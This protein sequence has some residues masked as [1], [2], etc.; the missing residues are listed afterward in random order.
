MRDSHR[1]VKKYLASI[2]FK[3][4]RGGKWIYARCL[5]PNMLGLGCAP[6][7]EFTRM[8]GCTPSLLSMS[9]PQWVHTQLGVRPSRTWVFC[10]SSCFLR[11]WAR[12]IIPE[13]TFLGSFIVYIGI[14]WVQ[15]VFL[16]WFISREF[17][18]FVLK[19]FWGYILFQPIK[20]ERAKN[21]FTR[22]VFFFFFFIK[23]HFDV[24]EWRVQNTSSIV[25][26]EGVY[27]YIYKGK[28]SK[29]V[30]SG[31]KFNQHVGS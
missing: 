9:C 18:M 25:L 4:I 22:R 27:I 1:I 24:S 30:M 20:Y 2:G 16:R 14:S 6:E 19:G 10:P 29:N 23:T 8:L 31:A 17:F 5:N 21:Q 13:S 12:A 28:D 7:L 11:S 15:W 26:K 3:P